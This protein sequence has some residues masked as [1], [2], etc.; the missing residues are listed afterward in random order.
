MKKRFERALFA[1]AA[2][3]LSAVPCLAQAPEV[4]GTVLTWASAHVSG[5]ADPILGFRYLPAVAFEKALPGGAA[6][7]F[8]ASLNVFGTAAGA[9]EAQAPSGAEILRKVDANLGS[10][11]KIV[12]SE[13]TA[14]GRP[15]W[16]LELTAKKEDTAYFRRKAWVDRERFVILGE[17]MY[18]RSGK[19]LK[20]LEAKSVRRFGSRWV[21]D[22][23]VFKDAMKTG[24]GTEFIIESMEFDAAIPDYIFSK[25]SL[26]R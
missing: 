2:A 8:E 20:N 3:A 9:G 4:S 25:A 14:L 13:E 15:C 6:L 24:D 11:A 17:E 5:P 23:M 10:D 1:A 12:V 26:R 19:L 18:A 16:V 21:Q 7:R 22:R